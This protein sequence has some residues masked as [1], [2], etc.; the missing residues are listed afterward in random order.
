MKLYHVHRFGVE[1][2]QEVLPSQVINQFYVNKSK[3]LR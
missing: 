3:A 2:I 1:S